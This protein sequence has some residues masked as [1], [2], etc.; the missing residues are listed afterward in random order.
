MELL[1][2]REEHLDRWL[3]VRFGIPDV[4]EGEDEPA[5]AAFEQPPDGSERAEPFRTG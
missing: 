4:A 1:R 2:H 3:G 5:F